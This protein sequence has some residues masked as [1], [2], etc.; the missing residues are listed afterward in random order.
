[1][2]GFETVRGVN[3]CDCEPCNGMVV[4]ELQSG[5]S[6]SVVK[7]Q[8]PRRRRDVAC[9]LSQRELGQL[10][11]KRFLLLV[12]LL[13]RMA[14]SG[15]LLPNVPLMFRL[16]SPIKSSQEVRR[17]EPEEPLLMQGSEQGHRVPLTTQP[18]SSCRPPCKNLYSA[19]HRV[20][21]SQ[22][23]KLQQHWQLRPAADH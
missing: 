5:S 10:I 12:F 17:T 9:M 23:R 22:W 3:G 21:G 1:M 4:H 15:F 20:C 13:E 18:K 2:V 11:L 14:V 19:S 6:T 7:M 16:D 8:Q